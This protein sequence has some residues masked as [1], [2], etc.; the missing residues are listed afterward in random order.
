MFNTEEE[1]V[2][3]YEKLAES[4]GLLF[5]SLTYESPEQNTNS[6]YAFAF[7]VYDDCSVP[8]GEFAFRN[9]AYYAL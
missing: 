3:H 7:D 5:D 2:E 4:K 9:G 1:L 6:G 8:I